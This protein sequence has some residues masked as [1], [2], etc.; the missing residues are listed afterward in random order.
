MN[1]RIEK[2]I[3]LIGSSLETKKFIA[4]CGQDM[5]LFASYDES[6]DYLTTF[7]NDDSYR[8][9]IGIAYD[10]CKP[11]F[12]AAQIQ[13][14]DAVIY[15]PSATLD[16]IEIIEKT[17][18]Q[19][20]QCIGIDFARMKM[21]ALTCLKKIDLFQQQIDKNGDKKL[22]NVLLASI[23]DENSV[24]FKLPREVTLGIASH[25]FFQSSNKLI[26]A[27]PPP[28]EEQPALVMKK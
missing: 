23:K 25:Y 4:S 14:A 17:R 24:F 1:T 12:F 20:K 13:N 7:L 8:F 27:A 2:N 9:K 21:P 15:L 19:N 11:D 18:H 16:E 10:C 6:H 3:I 22:A 5:Q 28:P 26:L